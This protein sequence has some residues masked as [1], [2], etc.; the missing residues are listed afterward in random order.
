M[1]NDLFINNIGTMFEPTGY[2]KANRN[3]TLALLKLGVRVRYTPIHAEVVR[4]ALE[5]NAEATVNSLIHTALPE[6]Y[7]NLFHYPPMYFRKEVRRYSIGITMYECTGL[8]FQWAR[9]CN[10]M[11]EIWVPSAFN[12]HTFIQSGVM[13]RKIRIMPFGVDPNMYRPGLPP[14]TIAGKRGY[15]FLTVCSFDERKGI[16][17]LLSAF[18]QEFSEDEDVSLIIK[19]RASSEEEISRQQALI[20]HISIAQSG[21]KRESVIL[22][23]T[24]QSWTEEEMA[25]LYNSVNCYV[26]PTRGE[27]WNMTV[28]EAMATGIPVITTGWSAHLDYINDTNGYLI[29]VQGFA[30]SS[31]GA[32]RRLWAIPNTAHLRQLMRHVYTHQDEANDKGSIGR[33]SVIHQYTWDI[34]AQNMQHRLHEISEEMKL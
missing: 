29:S 9:N 18:F 34:S 26:L 11:D 24:T 10:L 6:K 33:Q 2:A 19:T 3:L 8:P 20:D 7:M 17:I 5:P 21:R 15:T 22:L 30:P 28:M 23:S 31:P 16:D 12:R 27:G 25:R 1:S 14:L 4:I 32:S 13:P